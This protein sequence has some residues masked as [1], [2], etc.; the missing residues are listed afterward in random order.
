MVSTVERPLAIAA[1]QVAPRLRD[2]ARP[3]SADRLKSKGLRD[4]TAR[5]SSVAMTSATGPSDLHEPLVSIKMLGLSL[6]LDA[7]LT[8]SGA[9]P[10][11]PAHRAATL[12]P[13]A[14]VR[15]CTPIADTS[16]GR[17]GRSPA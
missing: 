10:T 6:L 5:I 17:T 13:T 8:S 4:G 16:C 12:Q 7:A 11:G 1:M 14:L 2:P 3:P 15:T 9:W